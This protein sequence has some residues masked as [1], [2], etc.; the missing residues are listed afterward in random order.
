MPIPAGAVH[1]QLV[2]TLNGGNEEFATGFWLS[3]APTSSASSANGFAAAIQ[4]LPS[5]AAVKSALCAMIST[6][7][8]YTQI[9]V[10]DYSS[11]GS[12][13]DFVGFAPITSGSG[14]G[15]PSNA[16]QVSA[17]VTL[18][19]EFAGSR[20]RGRMYL[21]ACGLTLAGHLLPT[22][23]LTNASTALAAWFTAINAVPLVESVVVVSRAGSD[24]SFVTSVVMDNRPDI[25]RRRA[26]SQ[27]STFKVSQPVSG[28]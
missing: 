21:P 16:L 4:A 25:Q 28:T 2:G 1:V 15:T 5:F 17:V 20:N 7:C 14:T 8:A 23:P 12:R 6:D 24:S 9:R 27:P 10:Y 26:E 11:G 22:A 18:L 19:T 13:A 3:G